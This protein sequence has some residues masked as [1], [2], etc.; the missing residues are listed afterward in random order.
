MPNKSVGQISFDITANLG[1]LKTSISSA[2]Q[3]ISSKFKS[4]FDSAVSNSGI[5]QSEIVSKLSGMKTSISAAAQKISDKFKNTF[6]SMADSTENAQSEIVEEVSET[7]RKINEILNNAE[8]NDK[9]R[10]MRIAALYRKEG[11]SQKEAAKKA[12]LHIERNSEKSSNNI[13]SKILKV[14][15]P[16]KGKMKEIFSKTFSSAF[17]KVKGIIKKDGKTASQSLLKT[18]I[19]SAVNIKAT[20]D[21]IIGSVRMVISKTKEWMS[22]NQTQIESEAR[23]GATMRNTTGATEEQI[24][25]IKDLAG[26][27]QGLGVVG[28]EVTLAGM[29]ELATYVENVE[30]LKTMMPVLD[31]MIAQQY[32]YNASTDS[33][34]TISTMLGKVLQGQTSALHRYGYTFDEAQ[35]KL[36]KYGTEEQRVATLAAVVSES[37]GGVN[38]ALANTP[39][40][41]IKQL[42]NDYGDLKETLGS[43]VTN[44]FYPVVKYLDVIVIKLN[45]L[46]STL[47]ENVKNLLGITNEFAG[48]SGISDLVDSAYDTSDA[49]DETTD[50]VNKLKK[51]TAGFD[52]LNILSSESS[53]DTESTET[54][55]PSVDTSKAENKF[56]EVSN[57]LKKWLENAFKPIKT[58]WDK[59]GKIVIE[60]WSNSLK[61]IKTLS[62]DIGKSFED[63]W[64][65]NSAQNAVNTVLKLLRTVGS[66]VFSIAE[67]FRN[68]WNDNGNGEKLIESYIDKLNAVLSIV[69]TIGE[70][71][72]NAWDSD[73]TGEIIFSNILQSIT[74]VNNGLSELGIN[75]D[76]AIGSQS[77]QQAAEKLID[78]IE[79]ITSHVKTLTKNFENWSKDIDFQPLIDSFKYLLDPIKDIVDN[80]LDGMVDFV[81]DVVQP[82]AKW[83]IEEAVPT[84]LKNIGAALKI[85]NKFGNVAGNALKSIWDNFLK[86]IVNFAGEAFSTFFSGVAD[87]LDKIA[88]S[89]TAVAVLESIVVIVGSIVA[90]LTAYNAVMTLINGIQM[91][92]AASGGILNAVWLANPVG[93][94][95]AGVMALIAVIVMVIAYWDDIVAGLEWFAG[96]IWGNVLEPV[97]NF[98]KDAWNKVLEFFENF[99]KDWENGCEIIGKKFSELWSDI[100]KLFSKIGDWFSQKFSEAWDGV[101]SAWANAGKFFSDTWD[102]IKNAFSNTSNWL[103]EQFEKAWNNVVSLFQNGGKIFNGMRDAIGDVFTNA[104]N[105]LIDGI[106]WVISQPFNQLDSAFSGIR[107]MDFFGNKP[108]SWLPTIEAPTIPH[109]A[110]GGLVKAPTLALVGDNKGASHDPEVVSPLS[111]LQGMMGSNPEIV[112]LLRKIITLLENEENIY[113]NVISL[114]GEVIER[115]LVKVRKRKNRR[116]GGMV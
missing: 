99:K 25:S 57:N 80:C 55:S 114:D 63:A 4:A 54:I 108:F 6:G 39:T 16:V 77:G 44:V 60:T 29:Q 19:S 85:I 27:I 22:A 116:Y 98:F 11:M 34:V 13:C 37:V 66:I 8:Y 97:V 81:N 9:S 36:L 93:I 58:S 89:S 94:V 26:E 74:N 47:N 106:N 64:Q 38:K 5:A 73:N 110:N 14:F 56:Q 65:S 79:T 53:S 95:V 61:E 51:A 104:V 92:A 82:I 2:T 100:K 70:N 102:K 43:L 71:F 84:A 111:K 62:K 35:E 101:K 15:E 45:N 103:G 52:Q 1:G 30:S 90:G 23:L 40:G 49:V 21:M 87:V 107:D 88:E 32:G 10:M 3:N 69:N 109:L 68:A 59:Y 83:T 17:S 112:P 86:H 31:D 18:F 7:Q 105:S 113:Q 91:A 67:S 33:A 42:S 12:W 20:L 75:F 28:D 41:K 96:W 48:G 50:A 78:I 76:N 24:Q 115:R 46:F 72:K